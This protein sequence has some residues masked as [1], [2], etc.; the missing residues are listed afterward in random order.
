M[1][2][3]NAARK[4]MTFIEVMVALVILF[5]LVFV[6]NGLL[7]FAMAQ[8]FQNETRSRATYIAENHLELIRQDIFE[9]EDFDG[10][11]SSPGYMLS[12]DQDYVYRVIVEEPTASLK[13]VRIDVFHRN[14]DSE[15]PT[16][17]ATEPNSGRITGIGTFIQRP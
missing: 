2:T 3:F 10:L 16:P 17:D 5:I 1:K 11:L 14:P 4:G 6:S 9:R 15:I 12:E 7:G 13:K 8:E